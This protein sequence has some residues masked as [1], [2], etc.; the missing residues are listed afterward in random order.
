MYFV[1]YKL[2]NYCKTVSTSYQYRLLVRRVV[3]VNMQMSLFAYVNTISH[4]SNVFKSRICTLTQLWTYET[5]K[6]AY[7]SVYQM[8]AEFQ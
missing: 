2:D 3:S 6:V 7:Y 1:I 5:R 8:K 4:G